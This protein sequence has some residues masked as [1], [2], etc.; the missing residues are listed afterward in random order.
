MDDYI[1]LCAWVVLIAPVFIL[2][3]SFR[4]VIYKFCFKK[5]DL[6]LSQFPH[7]SYKF[8]IFWIISTSF[9]VSTGRIPPELGRCVSG[10]EEADELDLSD[11]DNDDCYVA[12]DAIGGGAYFS[13]FSP[14]PKSGRGEHGQLCSKSK[15]R[16]IMVSADLKWT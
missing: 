10:R 2:I 6:A 3:I 16:G 4:V 7:N 15:Y 12:Q 13:K 14:H 8:S 9:L 5:K 1:D 11:Y